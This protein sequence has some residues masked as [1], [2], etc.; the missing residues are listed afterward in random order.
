MRILC[1]TLVLNMI[2][3]VIPCRFHTQVHHHRSIPT[4]QTGHSVARER[5]SSASSERLTGSEPGALGAVVSQWFEQSRD[6]WNKRWHIAFPPWTTLEALLFSC[7]WAISASSEG[8]SVSLSWMSCLSIA[9][10]LHAA[11]AAAVWCVCVQVLHCC[12]KRKAVRTIGVCTIVLTSRPCDET[13]PRLRDSAVCLFL[14]HS[15]C[16]PGT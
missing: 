3:C 15:C 7:L 10:P 1:E 16:L 2:H 6:F 12:T 14:T 4:T 8:A 9:V 5:S 11:G 13:A